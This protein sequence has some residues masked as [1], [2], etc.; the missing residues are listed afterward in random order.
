MVPLFVFLLSDDYQFKMQRKRILVA[1]S[2]LWVLFIPYDFNF[3]QKYIRT[4]SKSFNND[5]VK[6]AN[7][8]R[9]IAWVGYFTYANPHAMGYMLRGKPSE[10]DSLFYY[11]ISGECFRGESVG[12]L[13]KIT[14]KKDDD[15]QVIFSIPDCLN[16]IFPMA[17]KLYT[18]EDIELPF[19]FDDTGMEYKFSNCSENKYS[20]CTSLSVSKP[21]FDEIHIVQP[22]GSVDLLEL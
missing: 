2:V 4:V 20:K 21:R 8:D 12:E 1:T 19:R 18:I 17:V 11:F 15:G 3:G 14:Y 7:S 13:G 22:D 16:F 9:K 6:H 10:V 5:V